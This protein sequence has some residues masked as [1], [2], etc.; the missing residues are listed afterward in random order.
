M[1]GR[2]DCPHL[3]TV[4]VTGVLGAG[5]AGVTTSPVAGREARLVLVVLL[6]WDTVSREPNRP[7]RPSDRSVLH[8]S[9]RH[10]C[11]RIYFQ[12][13][14]KFGSVV[15][16]MGAE[17]LLLGYFVR[18]LVVVTDVVGVAGRRSCS[19]PGPPSPAAR[20]FSSTAALSITKVWPP[21]LQMYCT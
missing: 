10:K 12:T 7:A 14:V 20:S 19:P 17:F 18:D 9:C 4:S 15:R 11:S 13:P 2:K 3:T 6:V 1:L 21:C 5:L 8:Q 16:F